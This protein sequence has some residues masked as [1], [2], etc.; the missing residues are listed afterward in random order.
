LNRKIAF[1]E[2]VL[3]SSCTQLCG[4]LIVYRGNLPKQDILV[5]SAQKERILVYR[6]RK[7]PL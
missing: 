1:L 5:G 3:L 2:F 4:S 6:R 7:N